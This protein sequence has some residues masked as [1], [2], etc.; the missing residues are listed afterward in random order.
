MISGGVEDR[1]GAE[2]ATNDG[3]DTD[4]A[5]DCGYSPG[6]GSRTS[7]VRVEAFADSCVCADSDIVTDGVDNGVRGRTTGFF[8]AM[9]FP[10]LSAT[11]YIPYVPI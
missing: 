8:A 3:E 7:G 10:C 1:V 5:G 4:R 11:L 2:G 6:K 9:I